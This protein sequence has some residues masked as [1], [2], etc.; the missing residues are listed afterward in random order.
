MFGQRE[1]EMFVA[2]EFSYY[3]RWAKCI[4]VGRGV[5]AIVGGGLKAVDLENSLIVRDSNSRNI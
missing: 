1:G 4:G 5:S 2:D 3:I